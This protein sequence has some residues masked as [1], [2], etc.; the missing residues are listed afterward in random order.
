MFYLS[1]NTIIH[2]IVGCVADISR[3]GQPNFQLDFHSLRIS[4]Y[5]VIGKI[6]F[7]GIRPSLPELFNIY[8]IWPHEVA[9]CNFKVNRVV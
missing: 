6:L 4:T 8:E 1:S 7:Q 2:D 9:N 3:P 5:Q